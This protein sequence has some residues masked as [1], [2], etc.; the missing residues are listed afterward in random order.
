MLNKD[1][2]KSQRFELSLEKSMPVKSTLKP[3]LNKLQLASKNKGIRRLALG[4]GNRSI[5]VEE[6]ERGRAVCLCTYG[7][8]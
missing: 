6:A 5:E 2:L 8:G 1:L 3:F 4:H 7:E